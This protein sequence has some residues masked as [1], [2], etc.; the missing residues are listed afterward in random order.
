MSVSFMVDPTCITQG[1]LSNNID[2]FVESAPKPVPLI[3]TVVPPAAVPESGV[4]LVIVG[5]I[6]EEYVT[7]SLIT[8]S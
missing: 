4:K 1:I 7:I 6:D 2:T 8:K 5:V 3:A